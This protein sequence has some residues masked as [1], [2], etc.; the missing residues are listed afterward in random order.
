MSITRTISSFLAAMVLV[1]ATGTMVTAGAATLEELA[2]GAHR[3][4]ENKARNAARHPVETL[5]FFGLKPDMTVVELTPATGWYTEIIAPYVNDKGQ[6]YG[7][8]YDR[9]SKVEFMQRINAAFKAKLDAHPE[10]YGNAKI[11]DLTTDDRE[12]APAGSADMVVTFRNLH[13]WVLMGATDAIFAKVYKALKP[14]G[15][16]GVTE[17]RQDPSKPQEM[18]KHIG[19]TR[20]DYAIKIIEAAGF[21][22]VG[23]SEINA[24]PKDP[25][26]WEGGTHGIPKDFAGESDRFTLKFQKPE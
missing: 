8:N 5:E 2:N 14:G 23:Q 22:L 21:K 10:L 16:F 3:S 12:I 24:N 7:A 25:K 26:D 15:I 13:D 17:A 4:A 9:Q 18:K 11:T 6:Y 1:V 20:E 19:Y